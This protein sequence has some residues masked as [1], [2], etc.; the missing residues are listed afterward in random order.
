MNRSSYKRPGGLPVDEQAFLF[1]GDQGVSYRRPG[2]ILIEE[3]MVFL[4]KTASSSF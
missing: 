3:P 2:G 1:I 4:E